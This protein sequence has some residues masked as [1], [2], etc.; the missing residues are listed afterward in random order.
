M[1]GAEI[2]L[3]VG[4]VTPKINP[5][6]GNCHHIAAQAKNT[7]SGRMAENRANGV[8]AWMLQKEEYPSYQAF[9]H[10]PE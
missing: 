5:I 3:G 10:T 7:K 2:W 4:L 6:F 9:R 8:L 1:G